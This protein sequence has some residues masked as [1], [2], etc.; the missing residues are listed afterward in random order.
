MPVPGRSFSAGG[1]RRPGLLTRMVSQALAPGVLA[2]AV[3]IAPTSAEAQPLD[4]HTALAGRS[5]AVGSGLSVTRGGEW[6]AFTVRRSDVNE[7]HIGARPYYT[8]SGTYV[9]MVGTDIWV[10]NI[11][12]GES[13][14]LTAGTANNWAPSW[15]PDGAH[16]AYYSDRSGELGLWV[17]DRATDRHRRISSRI[18][19]A[20][21]SA[22]SGPHWLANGGGIVTNLLPVGADLQQANLRA[23]SLGSPDA[24]SAG[25][26]MAPTVRLFEHSAAQQSA[27]AGQS[28]AR[29]WWDAVYG[30]R[31]AV[32]DASTGAVRELAREVRPIWWEASPD[33]RYT[34]FM[35]LA[36]ATNGDAPVYRLMVI[37]LTTG[38]EQVLDSA[39]SQEWGNAVR[40][41]PGG[42]HL[43]YYSATGESPGLRV[44]SA[45]GAWRRSYAIGVPAS[46]VPT[47]TPDGQAI[48]GATPTELWRASLGGETVRQPVAG[49]KRIQCIVTAPDG[50][51]W[52]PRGEMV[53]C[54]NDNVTLL[55]GFARCHP[56]ELTCH[57]FTPAGGAP[58]G[59]LASV[60]LPGGG[61]VTSL[62]TA[63]APADL[64]RLHPNFT[65]ARQLSSLNPELAGSTRVHRLVEWKGADGKQAR[66]VLLLPRDHAGS[67]RLPIVVSV[68]PGTRQSSALSR[69][70]PTHHILASRGYAVFLPDMPLTGDNIVREIAE[71]VLAGVD[72]LIETGVAD[73]TRLAVMGHSYGGYGVLAIITQ[74]PRFRAAIAAASQANLI[75]AYGQLRDDGSSARITWT[76]RGQGGMRGTPW[77]SRERYIDNSPFFSFDRVST[78]LLLLHGAADPNTPVHQ[79]DATFVGLRRLNRRVAY[80]RYEG[81][82]HVVSQWTM[83]NQVDYWRRI[84][85][86]LDEHLTKNKLV[87]ARH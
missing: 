14:L 62:E 4:I 76:E 53:V 44:I 80:A 13:K 3:S 15:S 52:L 72:H 54:A 79:A 40:W 61:V 74:T 71:A 18:V 29:G 49:G 12:T 26:V 84:V 77:E 25:G 73:S 8:P 20:G 5:L 27:S 78:P 35:H 86:W 58:G 45:D 46:G 10:S 42:G 28:A 69:F 70:D 43:A 63:A 19:R 85:D 82:G 6:I 55:R 11:R 59:A 38:S 65:R 83:V 87:E 64:W 67:E 33:G 31:L 23:N 66:G 24:L 81:E 7:K 32:L 68:Y 36:A 22:S 30:G 37:D 1:Q 51:L 34:A 21:S 39:V 41:S 17:W 50:T 48:L 56:R 75:S 9:Y 47:W 16:L 57:S 60:G 2:C